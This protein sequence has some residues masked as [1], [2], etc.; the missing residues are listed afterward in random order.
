MRLDRLGES[1]DSPGLLSFP[2]R[3]R[4]AVSKS[5]RQKLS[6]GGCL[7]LMVASGPVKERWM[8]FGQVTLVRQSMFGQ[9]RLVWS[10]RMDR[11]IPKHDRTGHWNE[12]L[13]RAVF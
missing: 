2:Q 1:G 12:L 9:R 3:R 13:P 6:M 4:T 11:K 10:P 8:F 5:R 7:P